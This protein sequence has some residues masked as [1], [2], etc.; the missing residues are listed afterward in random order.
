[1]AKIK[2]VFA[3][4]DCA[5]LDSAADESILAAARRQHLL[6]AS[7]CEVGDCQTCRASL[8]AGTVGYDE[9]ASISLTSEEIMAGAIL[10]CVAVPQ[11]DVVVRL[12]YARIQRLPARAWPMRVAAVERL[13]ASAVRLRGKVLGLSP[14]NFCP[15]QYL[16][17]G[18][19]G[20]SAAGSY[21]MASAPEDGG[22]VEFLVR[23]LENGAVSRY[24]TER[25]SVG[26]RIEMHGPLGI[27]YLR[28]TEHPI[29]MVAGGAGI[30]PIA[31]MLRSLVRRGGTQRKVTLCFG[32]NTCADLFY[33]DELKELARR[34]A[35]FDLKITVLHPDGTWA[36][37][38][39]L[40]TDLIES[41]NA[42]ATDAYL[43][44]PP[45][46]VQAARQ[47]LLAM[48]ADPSAIYAEQFIPSGTS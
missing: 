31:S 34:F 5:M 17:L 11:S 4:G 9:F 28:E 35:A 13:C 18:V 20:S 10:P 44:G 3:D 15:D 7:D 43:C 46:M 42:P 14:L 39:G 23:L 19:P 48:G 29:L 12:P 1:M 45:P 36:G 27:F 22:E 40:V 2:F 33:V 25:A 47:K 16:D 32:V 30:A 24:L 38:S 37:P 26:D 6:L 21:S 8:C 41:R